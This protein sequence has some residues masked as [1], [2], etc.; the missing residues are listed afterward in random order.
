M[1]ALQPLSA[2]LRQALARATQAPAAPAAAARMEVRAAGA[3]TV[4]VLIYGNIGTS[5]WDDESVTARSV[6]DQL[7]E[8]TG[9]TINV[10]INSYGGSV[11]DGL[12]IHNELRRHAKRGAVVNVSVDAIAGSIASLIAVAGTTVTMSANAMMMLHAPWG[13]LY[14]DG[15]AKAVRE[16]AEEFAAVLD[17]MGAAM[18]ASYARKT[19]K[20]AA[21]YTAM[22][23]TGKD[24]WYSADDAKA[25][26]LCDV[27]DDA[28]ADDADED[29]AAA[30]LATVMA[31]APAE[32]HA[33]LRAAFRAPPARAPAPS[34][35]RAPAPQ[36]TARD[37]Q[38]APSAAITPEETT[39]ADPNKPADNTQHAATEPQAAATA[40][41]AALRD[42]NTEIRAIAADHMGNADVRAYVDGVIDAAD[43]ATTPGDV[44]KQIL[45]ILAK[46]RQ[47]LN[48]GGHVVAGADERDKR[49]GAMGAAL[50]ARLGHGDRSKLQGNAFV[51]LTLREMARAAA[52]HAG[53]DT[54]GM[55]PDQFVRAA[56]THT[57]SDFPALLGGTVSRAVLRGYEAWPEVYTE[58]ARAVSVP[59]FR[60]QSLAG[61]GQFIGIKK[62]PE[63]GE[64]PYGTF[65]AAGQ[66]VKLSKRGG[67][68][69]ITD[70]AIINDDLSLLDAVPSKM[71]AAA[72]RNLGDDVFALL[73]SNPTL[74][75]GVALFHANHANLLTGAALSTA[76]VDAMIAKMAMQKDAN[77]NQIRVP[78]KFIA[79]PVGL[80]GLARQILDSQYE[81]GTAKNNTAPNYVR[82]RFVVIEDP[83]LDA[84]SATAW[85]GIADPAIVDSL[86]IAYRDGVQEPV[87]TQ[88]Q[89][90][91][92]D[93]IEIK[94]RLDAEPAVVDY[95]GLAKNPGA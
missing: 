32:L 14:I 1:S 29:A 41:L 90:W 53:V 8:F 62:I 89:G 52:E 6:V 64:Y 72:K 78:L 23:D 5:W 4:D 3:D 37:V 91:N 25:A 82:N 33:N 61:L 55:A 86:V 21:D 9:G 56:I 77:G 84:A 76:A 16:V 24:Y 39:M 79:V 75:D 54:R 30:L 59:D 12:A 66:S 85:Y 63:G 95:V 17:V 7:A 40:A 11:T 50:D 81:I 94:V 92:V 47:P 48:G 74:S 68:F 27:I 46:G 2:A 69:S 60:P 58:L 65:N 49:V 38:A 71:G 83:R 70:E 43:P 67:I 87:V 10:R 26:G 51:G 15:N 35:P 22:W 93:G 34:A 44:G 45:A 88:K 13:S 73:T 57:S 36:A 18:A 28:A 31:A 42:R 19:G 20:S 80:G